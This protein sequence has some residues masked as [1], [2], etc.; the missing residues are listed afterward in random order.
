VL[1]QNMGHLR[2]SCQHLCAL[3]YAY[4]E[5]QKAAAAAVVVSDGARVQGVGSCREAATSLL[6]VAAHLHA[7]YCSTSPI[8][9]QADYI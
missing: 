3:Q 2:Q 8:N 1:L 7:V 6:F 5:H 4:K 9:I